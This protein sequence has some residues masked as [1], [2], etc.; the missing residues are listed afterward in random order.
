MDSKEIVDAKEMLYKFNLTSAD[1][2]T[3]RFDGKKIIKADKV[4]ETGLTDTTTL[5]VDIYDGDEAN[6]VSLATGVLKI[7]FRDFSKQ[8]DTMEVINTESETEQIKWKAKFG[9]FFASTLWHTY[10]GFS[11]CNYLDP[12]APPR[13]K[14]PL[15]LGNAVPVMYKVFTNDNVSI[16]NYIKFLG[17]LFLK[18][19]YLPLYIRDFPESSVR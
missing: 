1:N 3:Y 10:S 6:V 16:S 15:R 8:L 14:R 2:K 7:A 18:Y 4:G 12:N 17:C 19:H 5:F 13:K 9:K 11:E